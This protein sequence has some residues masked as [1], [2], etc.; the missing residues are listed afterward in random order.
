MH[1]AHIASWLASWLE[2]MGANLEVGRK[3]GAVRHFRSRALL[4]LCCADEK[5]PLFRNKN[6]LSDFQPTTPTCPDQ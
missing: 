2:L 3:V 4:A 5:A 1:S 6:T